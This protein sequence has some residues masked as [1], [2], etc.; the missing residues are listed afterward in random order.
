MIIKEYKQ[1]LIDSLD[2][3]LNFNSI[4][5]FLAPTQNISLAETDKE[6]TEE[7]VKESFD[8]KKNNISKQL[9]NSFVVDDNK[10]YVASLKK[11]IIPKIYK[12]NLYQDIQITKNS[13]SKNVKFSATLPPTH[14]TDTKPPK[15]DYVNKEKDVSSYFE[16]SPDVKY[17]IKPPKI[18]YVNKEKD[19]SSYFEPSPD[20]KYDIKPPKI[21]Y[22]NKEK[23]VSSYFEPKIDY[24]NKEKDVSSYFEPSPDVKYDIKPPK[25]DYVNKEKDISSYFE[26][27]IDYV[28]KEKDVSSY[29]VPSPGIRLKIKNMLLLS[30][31]VNIKDPVSRFELEKVLY[32]I[33]AFALGIKDYP[34]NE[35][36]ITPILTG[37]GGEKEEVTIDNNKIDVTRPEKNS[38]LGAIS[39]IND[40]FTPF[41]LVKKFHNMLQEQRSKSDKTSNTFKSYTTDEPTISLISQKKEKQNSNESKDNASSQKNMKQMK[42]SV[43]NLQLKM[44]KIMKEMNKNKKEEDNTPSKSKSYKPNWNNKGSH[45]PTVYTQMFMRA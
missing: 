40:N 19:V 29:F 7:I 2:H 3:F 32:K 15:I 11:L 35:N 1:S 27:K 30:N 23:D 4:F 25:I 6:T 42:E 39:F 13:K 26:P 37:E 45:S 31:E 41:G 38:I 24:V 20:V 9:N 5:N 17:D 18:D 14:L 33:P 44:A 22:V 10:T 21:D 43:S 16:S 34:L 28:N 36:N 8:F 12:K